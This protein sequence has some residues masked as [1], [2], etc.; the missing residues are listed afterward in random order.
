MGTAASRTRDEWIVRRCQLGEPGAFAE[1]VREMERPLLYYAVK[2]VTDEDLALDVLQ[3]VWL[4]AFRTIRRLEEPRSL[5]TWLYRIT[6]GAAVDRVRKER[7]RGDAE[8]TRAESS[9]E[10]AGEGPSFDA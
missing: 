6:R 8:R 10:E 5:R 2:L 4:V 9:P 3:E 1:L 7:S